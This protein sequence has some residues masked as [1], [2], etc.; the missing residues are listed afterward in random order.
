MAIAAIAAYQLL[1]QTRIISDPS[2]FIPSASTE[3]QQILIDELKHGA[4]GRLWIIAI[5]GETPEILAELNRSLATALV[6]SGSFVR[7]LN[8]SRHPD[9]DAIASIRQYRFLLAGNI[10]FATADL[11]E[12]LLARLNDLRS[13]MSTFSKEM[14]ASDPVGSLLI[15]QDSLGG[16]SGTG[17]LYNGVWFSND[18]KTSFMI[19]DTRVDGLDLDGQESVSRIINTLFDR[20]RGEGRATLLTSGAPAIALA[21]RDRI[22][23]D[24]QKFSL[25]A[26]FIVLA[27]LFIAYR[28]FNA[29]LFS[30]IPIALSILIA[31]AIV[32]LVFGSVHGITLAF[33]ITLL[34]VAVDYPV[35]LLSHRKSGTDLPQA[36]KKIWPVIRLGALTTGLGYL[37]MLFSGFDGLVQLG[38]FSV[39]GIAA[40]V[41]ITRYQ[42]P[43]LNPIMNDTL[44][45]KS[46]YVDRLMKIPFPGGSRIAMLLAVVCVAVLIGSGPVLSEDLSEMSP[47]P[48]GLGSRDR[49]LRSELGLAEPRYVIFVKGR[50]IEE[51]LQRQE[52]TDQSLQALKASRDI[53]SIDIASRILPSAAL[54]RRRQ[55]K[56]PDAESLS[57]RMDLAIQGTPFK[58]GSFKKF[59]EDVE[60]SRKLRP[61]ELEDLADT[62]IGLSLESLLHQKPGYALGVIRLGGV[63]DS[64]KV[65][66]SIARIG[67]TNI[68]FVDLKYATGQHVRNFSQGM[69]RSVFLAFGI[70]LI[71]LLIGLRNIR[72]TVDVVT[73]VAASVLV[74]AVVSLTLGGTLNL[75]HLVSLLLVAG[76]GVDYALFF[77][78]RWQ[79][80][81]D[82]LGTFH[83]L[84]VCSLSTIGVF[85][86]L[87]FSDVPVLHS[88]GITVAVGAFS[89]FLLSWAS[90]RKFN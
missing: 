82:R 5:R 39:T 76:L 55:Q 75:F 86:T 7:V 8:G 72:R 17:D 29:L 36:A 46:V 23:G 37:S 14:V 85:A 70:I 79:N 4:A 11:H 81:E 57:R 2:S 43:E 53:V 40:A 44:E 63:V 10:S 88:I 19:A 64:G 32:S 90:S 24:S 12:N 13:P 25:I 51:V 20:I 69:L 28:K 58:P 27:I 42:L 65:E 31:S 47:I 74:A 83:S 33:G 49:I 6:N 73:P 50:D 26:S 1:Y 18:R 84:L 71:V 78:Q 67:D 59:V 30:A 41:M 87:S 89:S 80:D 56:L 3:R 77:T 66:R 21:T 60:S 68:W 54:Q 38:V 45:R 52:K 22:R 9:I 16:Q 34:G 61:L 62:S 48:A 35:H 15:F